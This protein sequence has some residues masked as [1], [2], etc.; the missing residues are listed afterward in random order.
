[1]ALRAAGLTVRACTD[2]EQAIREAREYPPDV[3]IL[4]HGVPEAERNAIAA[5]VKAMHP[6]TQVVF[7]YQQTI[8]NAELADAILNVN[9]HPS[10]LITTIE[11]LRAR[12]NTKA[13]SA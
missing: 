10:D 5:I 3:V 11:Y 2:R 4:G 13:N 6:W 12:S 1:M 7:L 9:G 8:A